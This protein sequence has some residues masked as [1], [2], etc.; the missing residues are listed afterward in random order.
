MND[1]LEE[2]LLALGTVDV[3]ADAKERAWEKLREY[4]QSKGT[5]EDAPSQPTDQGR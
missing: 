2:R 3:P 4:L 1:D 5:S